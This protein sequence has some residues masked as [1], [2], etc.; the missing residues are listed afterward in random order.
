MKRILI[1]IIIIILGSLAAYLYFS[2][3]G[4]V[5]FKKDI[6]LYEAVPVSSPFFFEFNSIRSFPFNNPVT[7][8][9]INADIG[10]SFFESLLKLD[11]LIRDSEQIPNSLRS[12]P[13][14]LSFGYTGRNQLIPLIIKKVGSTVSKRNLDKLIRLYCPTEKYSYNE[15]EYGKYKIIEIRGINNGSSLFF[16]F[17]GGLLLL[18]PE[19]LLLEQ[20]VRQ[21]VTPGIM[22]NPYFQ[23]AH[24]TA[25]GKEISLYINHSDFPGFLKNILNGENVSKIDEFGETTY[26]CTQKKAERFGDFAAWSELDFHFRDDHLILTGI[27][28]ADDSLNH[29]LSVFNDQQPVNFRADDILPQ[30]TSFFCSYSFSDKEKFFKRLEEFYTHSGYYYEREE[31]IKRFERGFRVNLRNVFS[32]LINDEIIISTNTIPVNPE[33]KSAFFILHIKNKTEAEEQLQ[34][35]LVN[36]AKRTETETD[37]LRSVITV[38]EELQFNIYRFPYPSFPGVWLGEPFALAEANYVAFYDNFM[39]FSNSEEGLTSYLRSMILG[40]TLAKDIHYMRF[41]K[42]NSGR[43]NLNVYININKAYGFSNKIFNPRFFEKLSKKEENIRKFNAL[44]WQIQ[45]DRDIFFNTIFIDYSPD[46]RGEAQTIWQSNIGNNI[47]YKPQLVIN[48]DDK[49]EREII[50]QDNTNTLH[51]VT[52]QGIVR[53]SISLPGPVLSEIHQVDYYKNG[54]LQYLFNTNEKIFLIDRNGDNVDHFPVTLHSPATNGVS[55]FDYNNN[56]DYR[57]FIAGEDK[58]IYD[59]DHTGKIVEGWLF[60]KTDYPVTTPVQH[61]RIVG[62]DYIVFKDKTHIYIQNRRGETRV[63]TKAGFENSINPLVLIPDGRPKIVADDITGK[64]YYLY[65]NGEYEERETRRFSDDHYF[66]CDDLDGNGIIDYVFVDRNELTVMDENGKKL[67]NEKFENPVIY[68]PNIYTFAY[69]LK[70]VGIVEAGANKIYLFNPDGE[71]HEG[72]PFQGNSEF[73]IGK[74]SD[75]SEGLNLLVGSEGG[76]L[77]NYALED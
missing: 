64:V 47:G 72:F 6:S 62:K 77:Y 32:E 38:D 41:K 35:L 37:K 30:N 9:I 56:R 75:S 21:L 36:Y 39:V 76:K 50:I 18:G 51:Q 52:N 25:N 15:K 28:L 66:T 67:Y 3:Q 45:S 14:I 70:K 12:D 27:S 74:L 65:F 48:H 44:N 43:G 1:L 49:A 53:W 46:I 73:S 59:Y 33:N 8:E 55:V 40:A 69:N 11:S 31:R 7:N 26:S 68:P 20:A 42:N 19:S 24:K 10:N 13:F 23:E 60:D 58:K 22:N 61:F 71:L 34:D 63:S 54:K 5:S 16:S 2:N 57:Y 4:K 17:A 29:F